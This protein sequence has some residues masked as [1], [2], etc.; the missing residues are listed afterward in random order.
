MKDG[1]KK[2]NDSDGNNNNNNNLR[3]SLE[4]SGNIVQR[5][6]ERFYGNMGP[7]FAQGDCKCP[8]T[9]DFPCQSRM[10]P[11]LTDDANYYSACANPDPRPDYSS[12]RHSNQAA[13]RSHSH[14]EATRHQQAIQHIRICPRGQHQSPARSIPAPATSSAP[15]AAAYRAS[16]EDVVDTF[17]K[18]PL[19]QFCLEP[20]STAKGSHI[21]EE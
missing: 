7:R 21:P 18:R 19:D 1:G 15:A 16:E 3:G 13:R 17:T 14:R 8:S 12:S 9:L 4:Q 10:C 2:G 5:E 20:P 6:Y 11:K